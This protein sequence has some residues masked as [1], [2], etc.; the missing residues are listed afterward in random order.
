[1]LPSAPDLMF[2]VGHLMGEHPVEVEQLPLL[3]GECGP[4]VEQGIGQKTGASL[5]HVRHDPFAVGTP[6]DA[7][8]HES[9]RCDPRCRFRQCIVHPISGTG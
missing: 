7:V 2:P 6:L 1:M 8:L 9:L 3:L 5:P 4:L